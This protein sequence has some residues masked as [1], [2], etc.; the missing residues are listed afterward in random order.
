MSLT[1]LRAIGGRAD[2][3]IF[4]GVALGLSWLLLLPVWTGPPAWSA[5]PSSPRS[6]CSRCGR[7]PSRPRRRRGQKAAATTRLTAA[8][9]SVRAPSTS[10]V[11]PPS[12]RT[13]WRR[14]PQAAASPASTATG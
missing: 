7:D 10:P 6:R 4:L 13:A 12:R 8:A 2:L 11:I 9:V 5:G 14:N 1:R 3:F